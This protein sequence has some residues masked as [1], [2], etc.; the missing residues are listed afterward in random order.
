MTFEARR[1]GRSRGQGKK[2]LRKHQGKDGG[3]LLHGVDYSARGGRF[4]RTSGMLQKA[5]AHEAFNPH[6]QRAGKRGRLQKRLTFITGETIIK[7][8]WTGGHAGAEQSQSLLL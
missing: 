1:F 5:Q 7:T 6:R 2:E 3:Q 4:Q 8:R